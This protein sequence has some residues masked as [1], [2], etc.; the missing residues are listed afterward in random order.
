MKRVLMSDRL[1]DAAR[2]VRT[3]KVLV[4]PALPSNGI[5]LAPITWNEILGAVRR[6]A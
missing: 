6:A 4:A 2:R 3:G 5:V 1:Q